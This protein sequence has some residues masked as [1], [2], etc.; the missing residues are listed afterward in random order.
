MTEA[1]DAAG[2]KAA[3]FGA[4]GPI[5]R[6]VTR[7]LLERGADVRVVSR[8]AERLAR[9]FGDTAA[10][11]HPADL[12][13]P[14]AAR[15]AAADRHLVIHAVGLPAESFE[16]HVPIARNAVAACREGG[17]RPFLVTS[18]W[19]YGPGDR[20]PMPEDR[21]RS[22][23]SRKAEVREREEEVFLEADGAVARLPDF[24]GPEEGYSL[25]NEALASVTAG[26]TATWP[27]D[28]DAPRD[29]LH[30]GDAGR[31]LVDLALR[32]EAYGE[33]WNVPGS[34]GATPRELLER[35]A[36]AAGTELRIRRIRPW[37]ARLVSIVRSDV[38]AFLDVMP[39]Y[40]APALLDTSKLEALLGPAEVTPYG[41][42][43]PETVA[44]MEAR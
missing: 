3:V 30:Y 13:D 1:R 39:L 41:E 15:G 33:P 38:R 32:E 37:M 42:G 18:Y 26:E 16:R 43:I 14:T 25:L 4:T 29:F 10:E 20:A 24:Y 11:R 5:G 9:D 44:W 27:G 19:S 28:P 22:G 7:V 21:P 12:E 2:L 17:A 23:D 40:E 35:A 36:A 34:G 8:S 31:L 6:Q